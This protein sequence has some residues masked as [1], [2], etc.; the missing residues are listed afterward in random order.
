MRELL[1]Q[2]SEHV[3]SLE[4][5]ERWALVQRVA[6]SRHLIKAPQL[7]EILLYISR[8]VLAENATSISELEIGCKVLGRRMDF[9]PNEDNIVRVQIRHLRKKLEEYFS[10]EGIEEPLIVTIPKG[11]YLPHFD[12]RP[13]PVQ[14]EEISVVATEVQASPAVV[15]I[16]SSPQITIAPAAKRWPW[17]TAIIAV[18]VAA[19][20]VGVLWWRH[21]STSRPA[22]AAAETVAVHDDPLWSRIF[23]PHRETSIVVADT[24]LVMIQDILDVDIPLSKYL[25][26]GYPDK[27]IGSVSSHELQAALRTI[28]G[29]QYTSL[30]DAI[31]AAKFMDLSH[32]FAAQTNLRYSRYVSVREFKEGNFVLIGSRRG[33]P[34]EQLFESELNF[35]IE[36]DRATH[37]YHLRNKSP[38]PGERPVYGVSSGGRANEDTYADIALLPNLAGTGYV[39]MLSGID[40]AATEA[41]GE[42]VTN[43]DFGPELTRLLNSRG[44]QPPASYIEIL[45]EAKATAGTGGGAKIIAY[46]LIEGPRPAV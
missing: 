32:R 31:L 12:L 38:L 4:E 7:R 18:V 3:T 27:L 41:A 40:M 10:S 42:L 29:R 19:L 46:R 13:E 2:H 37:Q 23:A 1:N 36:E 44:S 21:R 28:A 25:D 39:L 14:A 5:D 33:I 22:V 45:L 24:N 9:S 11:G 43:P 6:S 15:S 8:R 17:T 35:N 26:G 20:V 34:W 16:P 30:G